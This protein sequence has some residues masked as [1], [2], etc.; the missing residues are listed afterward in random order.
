MN[1]KKN[2]ILM[3]AVLLAVSILTACAGQSGSDVSDMDTAAPDPT[4]EAETE[5]VD[6]AE[7]TD[8]QTDPDMPQTGWTEEVPAAYRSESDHPGKVVPLAYESKNYS[9]SGETVSKTTYVYLPYGYDENDTETKYDIIYLMHGWGGHAGDYFEGSGKNMLDHMIESGEAKPVIAVSAS[10]YNENTGTDFSSSVSALRQ[11][12]QEF[13]NDLMP[14][15]EGQFHTYASGTT[16]EELAASRDHRAFGGFSL[17]SVTTW[18]Q[19]CYNSDYIRYFLP[20][21]GSCWYYGGFGDFQVEKNAD[22]IEQLVKDNDLDEE[23]YFIYF[24]V[25]TNDDVKSQ[26]I[27][28]ADE[29]LARSGT[30]TPDHFVFYQ[31]DGGYHDR[32]AAQEYIYNALPLFFRGTDSADSAENPEDGL[33]F[34]TGRAISSGSFSGTAY[35]TPMISNDDVYHFPQT[36]H[37][38]FEPGARSGWHSHGGMLILVTGGVGY[39]QEEGQ[40]AQIIRKGDVVECMPGVRHWHGAA[41]DSWFSQLVIYDSHY[42]PEE[43][44]AVPEEPVTDEHYANLE[45]EEYQERTTPEDQPFMFPKAERALASDTFSG[46][47]YV[48]TII[49][50]TNAAGA[51][52][53]HYVV[54]EPGVINNWHIHEGGQILIATDGIGYHQIKGEPVQ[55][56]Y[57]GD[58]ALC[59]PGAKHWHGGS[60]DTEF[61]HIAVNTNPELTG[62]QWFDRISEEEYEN[63]PKEK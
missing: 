48:S 1:R 42:I 17:G 63:L 34:P 49:G 60:A 62:L 5:T 19:F 31:K 16:Q 33:T 47:A 4:T 52:G 3:A 37:V 11:F 57:P 56:L 12:H 40:P 58:V 25:G 54:F 15:V 13:L 24:A 23:G 45:T 7:A 32:E 35:L 22:H 61:A 59:P 38:T 50:D 20:M 14:A 43:G 6:K 18:M 55:V 51:P 30:F 9:G 28:F 21:S 10:F 29:L 46:P 53:L 44:A 39:Y 2:I 8:G 26:S 36:N 27:D 41:P